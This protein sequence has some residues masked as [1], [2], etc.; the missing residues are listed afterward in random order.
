VTWQG[1]AEWWRVELAG[2]P[3]YE[4]QVTPLIID[5]LD[6]RPGWEVLDAGCGEGRLMRTLAELGATPIGIDI[7][8]ALLATARGA[9]PVV[10]GSLDDLGF[11]ADASVDAV[12][13]SLV[14]EHLADEQRFLTGAA[15]ITRPGG[16][17][18]VV[19]NH[20]FFTAPL[21]APIQE[22][23]EVLWRPGSYLER[24]HT[25]EPA[26][27]S[28]VRFHHRPLGELLTGASDAGW[29]LV[30]LVEHGVT[31]AQVARYPA[32]GDQRHIP[33]LLGVRW[34]RRV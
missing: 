9:G 27:G 14:L 31:D 17:L 2:D 23:D 22:P 20:P 13:V 4:E 6:A 7:E 5:L 32:L 10:L 28:F 18:A 33:R 8:R 25:D 1:L 3:A 11:L 34:V 16:V 15:G 26:G 19:M 21:S 30:R 29:D 24:G 12:V